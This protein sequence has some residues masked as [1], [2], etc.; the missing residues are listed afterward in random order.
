MR[1]G[2]FGGVGDLGSIIEQA[3]QAE[4]DGLDSFWVGQTF[5]LDAMCTMTL[6]G[7]QVPR[8]ELGT[9]VIPTYPRHPVVL[10]GEALTVS[11]ASGGRFTLGVG[12]SHQLVVES[13]LGLSYDKPAR[14]TRE[15]LSALVPL[16]AGEGV[17]ITGEVVS[18]HA[19]LQVE[20]ATPVPVMVAALGPKMLKIAAELT[21]GTITWMTGTKTLS[22]HIVPS[23]SAA[24]AAAGTGPMRVVAALPIG[25]TDDVDGAKER[26]ERVFSVYRQLPAY[27]A[28]FER[29]G[30]DGPGDVSL[31][32][33]EAE[34][35]AGLDRLRDGGVTDFIAVSFTRD[36][37]TDEATRALL[38]E[39][40][41]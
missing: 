39:Y 10:A 19:G 30:A 36:T 20:G 2:A 8:I 26:I 3:A 6:V 35:R 1:I 14:H 5:G 22:D 17:D 31:V 12:P 16:C 33:T 7:S 23:I 40:T 34:V 27:Q 37:T 15:Y 9:A 18:A 21:T 24:A 32:G 41:R 4:A 13:M 38:R 25:V 29:E 28:M 11:A